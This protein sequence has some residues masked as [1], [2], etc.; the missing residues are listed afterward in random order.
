M[1]AVAFR[2]IL[3]EHVLVLGANLRCRR[4]QPQAAQVHDMGHPK[5]WLS[6]TPIFF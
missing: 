6:G 5:T 4:L 2:P 3:S 1:V